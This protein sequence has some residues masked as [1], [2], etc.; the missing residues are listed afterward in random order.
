MTRCLR[1]RPP[2]L[3]ATERVDKFNS[4]SFALKA[5]TRLHD[6]VVAKKDI[7]EEDRLFKIKE[8]E[9]VK[10]HSVAWE[11]LERQQKLARDLFSDYYAVEERQQKLVRNP[12]SDDYAVEEGK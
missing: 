6:N 12:F 5:A 11:N 7:E 2:W 4:K 9:M 10:R 1:E 8:K 3:D